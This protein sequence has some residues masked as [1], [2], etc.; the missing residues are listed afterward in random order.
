MCNLIYACGLEAARCFM[1]IQLKNGLLLLKQRPAIERPEGANNHGRPSPRSFPPPTLPIQRRY[2]PSEEP[3][4]KVFGTKVAVDDVSFSVEKGEVLGF[5]GPE[6]RRQ[7]HHHAHGHRLLPAH[8]RFSVSLG[9][10]DMLENPEKAK[11]ILGYLPE[12]AL[13]SILT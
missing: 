5:L 12:N 10:I 1:K 11:Q 8:Q 2:D 6:R 13:R 9:G 4:R 3:H 7:V